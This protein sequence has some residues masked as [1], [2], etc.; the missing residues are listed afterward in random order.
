MIATS[1]SSTN[2]WYSPDL[3][4]TVMTKLSDPRT[5]ETIYKLTNIVR[6]EQPL[7]LFEIPSDYTVSAGA[8]NL[9]TP[10]LR[11]RL[12]PQQ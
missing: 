10:K 6:V 3:Q 12:N 5:G 9:S 1:T 2:A 4:L 8:L 11:L 7:S